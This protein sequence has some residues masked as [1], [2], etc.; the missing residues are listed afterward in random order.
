MT[1]ARH[2]RPDP[3]LPPLPERTV[4]ADRAASD[5]WVL[6]R[7]GLAPQELA[8]LDGLDLGPREVAGARHD[9]AGRVRDAGELD[10]DA[11]G[12]GPAREP[13]ARRAGRYGPRVAASGAA[14]PSLPTTRGG[15]LAAGAVVLAVATATALTVPALLRGSGDDAVTQTARTV[16]TDTTAADPTSAGPS[17]SPTTTAPTATTPVPS[18][19]AA[20]SPEPTPTTES[21]SPSPSR[22]ATRT[23]TPTPDPS[24]STATAEPAPPPPAPAPPPP[25]SAGASPEV[26]AAEAEVLRLVNVERAKAGCP[27]L[28]ADGP[29]T[30]LARNFSAD[31]AA[32]GFFS[33][34]DPDGRSPWDRAAAAGVGNLRAENIARGQSTPD[35]VMTSWMNSK[36]H[37]DNILNCDYRTLG[38]GVHIATGGPWWTQ[39]FGA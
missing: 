38:V 35:Q 23:D 27:A 13:R 8:E 5:T 7:R 37:K 11:S 34:T 12:P 31:M 14:R 19:L 29:L 15:R 28:T 24:T 18:M 30:T 2:R 33:H 9:R 10:L 3:S 22:T 6:A 39:D 36:G 25:S 20:P 21:R 16:R 1:T 26:L 32:R 17:A 4:P